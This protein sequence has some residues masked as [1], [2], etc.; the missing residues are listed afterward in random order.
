MIANPLGKGHVHSFSVS[1]KTRCDW[2]NPRFNQS[3]RYGTLCPFSFD[4]FEGIQIDPFVPYPFLFCGT[5]LYVSPCN[6]FTPHL[7]NN[8][9]SQKTV[10][11]LK[12]L[13]PSLL[14]T[15][16]WPIPIL[17]L[18]INFI[19]SLT[20][21]NKKCHNL[22]QSVLFW[23]VY[24][25]DNSHANRYFCITPSL[26]TLQLLFCF[27][28]F[29]QRETFHFLRKCLSAQCNIHLLNDIINNAK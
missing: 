1:T 11:N 26:P 10:N 21:F 14:P 28:I 5:I 3:Q 13:Y 7:I 8:P 12:Q 22:S 15:E 19:S 6:C 2:S 18:F 29:S 27:Q 9:L 25:F 20:L 17:M 16:I 23:K 24:F 4:T